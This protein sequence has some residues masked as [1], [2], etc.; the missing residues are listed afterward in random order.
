MKKFNAMKLIVNMSVVL[1]WEY[2][3][4]FLT[5]TAMKLMEK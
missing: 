1:S 3:Q 4:P 5:D 2:L